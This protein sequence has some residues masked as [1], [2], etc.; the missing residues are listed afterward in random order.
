MC[1]ESSAFIDFGN[2]R[3]NFC[4]VHETAPVLRL[5]WG[6]EKS[7]PSKGTHDSGLCSVSLQLFI[8]V[9]WGI[10]MIKVSKN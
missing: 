5:G 2:M 3:D 9:T 6:E 4:S 8:T 1:K 10:M 7:P